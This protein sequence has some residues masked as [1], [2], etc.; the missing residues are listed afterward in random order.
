MTFT[1]GKASPPKRANHTQAETLVC[2]NAKVKH[3]LL[4]LAAPR[5]SAIP[6]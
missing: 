5:L 4:S 1:S 3:I 6:S 2:V